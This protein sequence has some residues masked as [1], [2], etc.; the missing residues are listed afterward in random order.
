MGKITSK[1]QVTVPRSVAEQLQLRPGDEL[2]WQVT[3]GVIRV[4]P[5]RAERRKESTVASR[6]KSFD[7]AVAREAKRKRRRGPEPKSRGWTRE[8][9][10]TRGRA[11]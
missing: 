8:E 5:V 10:Y 3:A 11:D 2:E 7:A 4:T 9:L 6:L 1:Y